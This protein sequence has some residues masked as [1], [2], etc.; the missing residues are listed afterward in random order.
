MSS[1]SLTLRILTPEATLFEG[2][3]S[4]VSLPGALA[5]FT[6]LPGHAAMIST[7]EKG[8]I[9]IDAPAPAGIEI[10]GG[11]VKIKDNRITVCAEI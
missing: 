1:K 3:A 6:V 10:R 2:E 11:V 9:T 5:P 4:A 8:C 7:L